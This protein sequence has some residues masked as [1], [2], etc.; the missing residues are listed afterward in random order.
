VL[1]YFQGD[2]KSLRIVEVFVLPRVIKP[3]FYC[4]SEEALAADLK[5]ELYIYFVPVM[6]PILD[7]SVSLTQV[8]TLKE[9]D[10]LLGRT[11]AGRCSRARGDAQHQDQAADTAAQHAAVPGQPRHRV[12]SLPAHQGTT[13]T[14]I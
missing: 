8:Q 5:C 14:K 9:T 6:F 7:H 10:G 12:H 13:P 2:E 11:R 4:S 3:R 1:W